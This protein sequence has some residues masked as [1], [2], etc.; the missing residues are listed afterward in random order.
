[1]VK[2]LIEDEKLLQKMSASILKMGIKDADD[3]IA[4]E[5]IKLAR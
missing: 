2:H 3:K 4:N 1:M 5:I